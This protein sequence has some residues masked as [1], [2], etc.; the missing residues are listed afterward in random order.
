[1][2]NATV[3]ESLEHVVKRLVI[4]DKPWKRE[5]PTATLRPFLLR[6]HC[7]RS[8]AE[9]DMPRNLPAPLLHLFSGPL[10]SQPSAG[11]ILTGSLQR[12]RLSPFQKAHGITKARDLPVGHRSHA[13]VC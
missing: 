13:Y 3:Y 5:D 9:D 4:D 10:M 2:Q 7:W 6:S 1:M 11:P 8:S 12:Q